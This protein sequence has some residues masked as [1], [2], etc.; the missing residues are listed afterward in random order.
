MN[1][2][3]GEAKEVVKNDL[4]E[5]LKVLEGELGDKPYYGDWQ[6]QHGGELVAWAHRC[7]ERESVSKT[8]PD[9]QKVYDF[10]LEHI[11]K[12]QSM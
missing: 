11:K 7:M 10:L 3:I 4:I 6:F 9:Q 12:L 1:D 5:C 2:L 8:L